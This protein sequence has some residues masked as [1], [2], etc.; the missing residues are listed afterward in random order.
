MSD[1]FRLS[2][3]FPSDVSLVLELYGDDGV[4][5]MLNAKKVPKQF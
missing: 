2:A 3:L 1:L 5:G 4:T